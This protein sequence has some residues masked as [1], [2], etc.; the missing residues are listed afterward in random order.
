M[1]GSGDFTVIHAMRK[2]RFI[3]SGVRQERRRGWDKFA[4]I[5]FSSFEKLSENC[6][7]KNAKV[8]S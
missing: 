3:G 2:Y 7:P 4:P 1:R 8:W 5:K 6:I